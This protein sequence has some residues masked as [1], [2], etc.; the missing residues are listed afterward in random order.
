[1]APAFTVTLAEFAIVPS[2]FSVPAFTTVL[3]V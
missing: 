1:L 3:P 2:T